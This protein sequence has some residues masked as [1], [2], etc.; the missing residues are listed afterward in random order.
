MADTWPVSNG[1][2]G[3]KSS[4]E[5]GYG[6]GKVDPRLASAAGIGPPLAGSQSTSATGSSAAS[7]S[8]ASSETKS[9]SKETDT[10]PKSGLTP[11]EPKDERTKVLDPLLAEVISS[12]DTFL[13]SLPG[14]LSSI[15]SSGLQSLFDKLPGTIQNLL[16]S[17]GLT[18]VLGGMVETL[19]AE[20]SNAMTELSS[21]LQSAAGELLSGLGEKISQIPGIGPLFQNFSNSIGDLSTN[22]NDAFGQMPANIQEISKNVSAQIAPNLRNGIDTNVLGQIPEQIQKQFS[23]IVEF[24]DNP[25]ASLINLT[26]AAKDIQQ[27]I[28]NFLPT[29]IFGDIS[30]T[31]NVAKKAMDKVITTKPNGNY[32]LVNSYEKAVANVNNTYTVDNG[33][34][35]TVPETFA[36]S[37]NSVQRQSFETYQRIALDRVDS[38]FAPQLYEE[39]VL[40]G[41]PNTDETKDL[42]NNLEQDDKDFISLIVQRFKTFLQDSSSGST[43]SQDTLSRI[44]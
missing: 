37:L 8:T 13:Q 43:L 24:K 26:G 31:A 4:T 7:P 17:T 38:E 16:N 32:G 29:N 18:S 36:D 21:K 34:V 15:L 44:G 20:L 28:L 11:G 10:K 9:A 23:N 33:E 40:T 42:Y 12:I 2:V 30:S 19:S 39:L 22:L 6:E 41:Y 27:K 25:V 14:S 35:K 3:E 1:S 5:V